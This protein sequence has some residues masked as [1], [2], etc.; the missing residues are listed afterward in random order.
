MH[1]Q[2]TQQVYVLARLGLVQE[3][4]G[5]LLNDR[6][7]NLSP[8]NECSDRCL[9]LEGAIAHWKYPTLVGA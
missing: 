8:R 1:K 2:A 5:D 4:C 6:S 9:L 3:D 7:V